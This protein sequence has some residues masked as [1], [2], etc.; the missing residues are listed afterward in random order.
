MRSAQPGYAL[1]FE[2]WSFFTLNQFTRICQFTPISIL[3]FTPILSAVS[4]A[5]SR[6]VFLFEILRVLTIFFEIVQDFRYFSFSFLSSSFKNHICILWNPNICFIN[7]NNNNNNNN[8]GD[9][10]NN[11]NNNNNNNRHREITAFLQHI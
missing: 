1:V 2:F 3:L 7:N 6:S 5:I 8:D 10:N 4:P 11:N 9:D